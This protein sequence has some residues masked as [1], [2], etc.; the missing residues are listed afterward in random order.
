MRIP[1]FV[2]PY[3]LSQRPEGRL[4]AGCYGLVVKGVHQTIP[5]YTVAVKLIPFD[6]LIAA[7]RQW[8]DCHKEK[9]AINELTGKEADAAAISH[10]ICEAQRAVQIDH[11]N[12]VRVIDAGIKEDERLGWLAMELVPGP[13]L[14]EHVSFFNSNTH[15]L[16]LQE[17][18]RCVEQTASGLVAIHDLGFVHD[19]LKEDNILLSLSPVNPFQSTFKIGDFSVIRSFRT[20]FRVH[21]N[22]QSS[23]QSGAS[24][25]TDQGRDVKAVATI[26]YR[27]IT[28]SDVPND[29]R[30]WF[31][32]P[33]WRMVSRRRQL[34]WILSSAL[35]SPS[36]F[37]Y[38]ARHLR[39][40]LHAY[41]TLRLPRGYPGHLHERA[42]LVFRRHHLAAP[43]MIMLTCGLLAAGPDAITSRQQITE[44]ASKLE[45]QKQ[46]TEEL[47]NGLGQAN[48]KADRA[49]VIPVFNT[50]TYNRFH[51]SRT[52][53]ASP[54]REAA[55][56]Y[57]SDL[58]RRPEEGIAFSP[59]RDELQTWIDLCK[60]Q[61]AIFQDDDKGALSI[62]SSL[63]STGRTQRNPLENDSRYWF[64][65]LRSTA[66]HHLGNYDLALQDHEE[67]VKSHPENG[68]SLA[69]L[70]ILQFLTNRVAD[71]VVTFERSLALL[72]DRPARDRE[73]DQ[74]YEDTVLACLGKAY[75]Y[76][77]EPAK[78]IA[79]LTRSLAS[80]NKPDRPRDWR[81]AERSTDLAIA[82]GRCGEHRTALE[83]IEKAIATYERIIPV[84]QVSEQKVNYAVALMTRADALLKLGEPPVK[85][86]ND[87]THAIDLL[88]LEGD[89]KD[90]LALVYLHR[91]E[92][93][94]ELS[95]ENVPLAEASSLVFGVLLPQILIVDYAGFAVPFFC[96]KAV[97]DSHQAFRLCEELGDIRGQV[98]SSIQARQ[99][100]ELYAAHQH[101]LAE[102]KKEIKIVESIP[103][104]DG[105][106]SQPLLKLRASEQRYKNQHPVAN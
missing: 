70:G 89:D 37:T 34:Q 33:I 56:R 90:T 57:L 18:L 101:V 73:A 9:L 100:Y 24:L 13:N 106:P 88:P 87:Y 65:R 41:R 30:Q 67:A 74:D 42:S 50:L 59:F 76:K 83:N 78:A 1:L 19:D 75:L 68:H 45:K 86:L 72:S 69:Q 77:Q 47:R 10:V 16:P 3:A 94:L 39:D 8:V 11:P 6:G 79:P 63:A 22:S 38:S 85:A 52:P 5:D 28:G 46:I 21:E 80:W 25:A 54:E 64:Y 15:C 36:T 104:P 98:R 103:T 99:C 105:L 40:A 61:L 92:L 23:V 26:L 17:A 102:F 44:I 51:K 14:K 32:E 7:H 20:S 29:C 81:F 49:A 97:S 71:A 53:L 66:Y 55:A 95:K 48:Y 62:L 12:V 58:I 82:F 2:G 91:G 35:H 84:S 96:S 43:T 60:V 93:L 4:G 27:L 31:Q